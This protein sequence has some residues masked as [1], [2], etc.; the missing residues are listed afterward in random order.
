MTRF[1]YQAYDQD[2]DRAG[3][4]IESESL[5]EAIDTLQSSGLLIIE[6]RPWEPK[7]FPLEVSRH[8]KIT[9]KEVARFTDQLAT[10][11]EAGQPLE[12]A[13]A[14]QARQ[15]DRPAMADLLNRLLD[16]VKGGSS[17][18]AAMGLEHRIFSNFYLS[19]VKAGEASGVLGETLTQ[20]A[21]S[22]ERSRALRSELIS[23]L[24]YPAFLVC[25]VLGS[26]VLLLTYVVPQFVPIFRDLNVPLPFITECI[27]GLGIFLA[28]W[29]V[30]LILI[31]VVVTW[32]L[33]A[34]L[35]EPSR[36]I[37]LDTRILKVKLLGKTLQGVETARF[38]LTLG[39]L[40]DRKVSL[41]ASLNITRQVAK[42]RAIGLA[43]E[44]ATVSTKDGCSLS[45]ALDQTRLFPE[46]AVQMIRVGEQSGRLGATLLK[47]ADV[48]DKET[49]TS[50]KRF[51]AALVP[52]LTLVMT[53]L[54]AVIMLAVMLPLL[55]LTSNI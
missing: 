49:Q 19:L 40:V 12:S 26:L 9:D 7:L 35:Q 54:V 38:A 37:A 18:S 36:R 28:Q 8:T 25:G 17:L 16:Q 41:L 6:V 30:Y 3:G 24:I 27:L 2:G 34:Y 55:S 47:L 13:L 39:T 31:F 48:Y 14:L 4:E 22:L 50:L 44:Q 20:L 33:C 15:A 32:W 23:A 43:L 1:R 11:L 5:E 29:G 21:T 52:T 51:M 42:N 46:L 53:V 45:V 10:L